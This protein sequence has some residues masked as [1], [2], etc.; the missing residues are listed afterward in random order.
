MDAGWRINRTNQARSKSMCGRFRQ[1]T[2]GRWQ[3]S[4]SGG[5][6]PLWSR[7]GRELFYLS[8]DRQCIMHIVVE[9]GATLDRQRAG[10][11]VR[12]VRHSSSSVPRKN[13]R[14]LARRSAV[15]DA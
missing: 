8:T 3:I 4:T 15:P 9:R 11:G 10:Q 13:I 1:S 12:R 7:D 2:S 14:R 5:T 6:R